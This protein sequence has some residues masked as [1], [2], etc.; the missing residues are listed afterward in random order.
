[1][2]FY[3][4]RAEDA[5]SGSGPVMVRSSTPVALLEKTYH[6][7]KHGSCKHFGLTIQAWKQSQGLLFQFVVVHI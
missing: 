4:T 1:M 6:L 5:K 3:Y 2:L 7:T